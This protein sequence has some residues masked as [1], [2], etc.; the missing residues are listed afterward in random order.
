MFIFLYIAFIIIFVILYLNNICCFPSPFFFPPFCIQW[1]FLLNLSIL[2]YC[3]NQLG[4]PLANRKQECIFKKH[5]LLL[6][7]TIRVCVHFYLILPWMYWLVKIECI[8][9]TSMRILLF[10]FLV[11]Q[12]SDSLLSERCLM[13]SILNCCFIHR[14]WDWT[15]K[16]NGS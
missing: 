16:H 15:D 5:L 6:F 8:I 2:E 12:I 7:L 10:F 4:N 11:E 1:L 14:V 3:S 13:A 9:L